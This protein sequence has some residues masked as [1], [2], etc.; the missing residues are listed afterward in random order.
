MEPRR[1]DGDDAEDRRVCPGG[2]AAA[3][4]PRRDDGDDFGSTFDDRANN[5]RPQWSPVVTTGTTG[6]EPCGDLVAAVAAMEPRR[7]DGDDA[8]VVRRT[9]RPVWAPQWSPV[10]TTGTTRQ[11]T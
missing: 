10:V 5:S 4:E 9:R 7:D 11:R 3:M 6:G 2:V 1:D 8:P